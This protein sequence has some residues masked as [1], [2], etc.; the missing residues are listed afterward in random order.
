MDLRTHLFGLVEPGVNNFLFLF[1]FTI[2]GKSGSMA[3]PQDFEAY[4]AAPAQTASRTVSRNVRMLLVAFAVVLTMVTTI[5]AFVGEESSSVAIE[6]MAVTPQDKLNQLVTDFAKH[7][8]TLS[9]AEMES[10]LEMWRNDPNTILDLP[11]E[12]RT[13]VP[14]LTKT[15]EEI[16]TDIQWQMLVNVD[17]AVTFQTT[18]LADDST[19]CAKKDIIIS[20]FD[21]LLKKLGG[22]VCKIS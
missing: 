12:A 4:G 11:E 6:D 19:L 10:K 15:C 1:S 20:K 13:Q 2:S 18:T 16:T 17:Q 5:S 3:V 9:V 22:E 8:A 21:Q 7:G 14:R